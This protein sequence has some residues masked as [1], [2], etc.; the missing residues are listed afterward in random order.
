MWKFD[1][2]EKIESETRE[3]KKM[4]NE[5][6]GICGGVAMN[7]CT[8]LLGIGFC[9]QGSFHYIYYTYTHHTIFGWSL[10][11][12]VPNRR[13]EHIL[14][15]WTS[16]FLIARLRLL[17][18]LLI[19]TFSLIHPSNGTNILPKIS[20]NFSQFTL[21]HCV[22]SIYVYISWLLNESVQL[23]SAL[24][25]KFVLFLFH[26]LGRSLFCS[27]FVPW[28]FQLS[29]NSGAREFEL[30]VRFTCKAW[31]SFCL[32]NYTKQNNKCYT[33]IHFI[34]IEFTVMKLEVVYRTLS[35][36]RFVSL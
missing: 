33:N 31:F 5:K 1:C 29:G 32:Q 21:V 25:F 10:P 27:L 16:F 22:F 9:V 15:W 30:L 7:G 35:L 8:K 26:V 3:E 4:A 11:F 20:H 19:M 34:H 12:Q 23:L 36:L 24:L 6:S 17:F 28:V 14:S 13:C 18:M 2:I